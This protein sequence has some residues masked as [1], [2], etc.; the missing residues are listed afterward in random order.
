MV[1]NNFLP[2]LTGLT[3]VTVNTVHKLTLLSPISHRRIPTAE[4]LSYMLRTRMLHV[5]LPWVTDDTH[6]QGSKMESRYTCISNKLHVTF[7]P[8]LS[9]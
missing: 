7:K 8:S 1:L 6:Q 2:V 3:R 9:S 5:N 4:P